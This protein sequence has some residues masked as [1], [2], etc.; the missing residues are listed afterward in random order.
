MSV[1]RGDSCGS[2]AESNE[3]RP[4]LC[5]A[6]G[7]A[8][9]SCCCVYQRSAAKPRRKASMELAASGEPVGA[10]S[11]SNAVAS[12]RRAAE[13]AS[14]GPSRYRKRPQ[15]L[16]RLELGQLRSQCLA[17]GHQFAVKRPAA[18]QRLLTAWALETLR[19]LRTP[20]C[21]AFDE[22]LV[23]ACRCCD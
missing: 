17:R 23:T 16:E 14:S 21:Y 15:L 20:A 12:I 19:N 3:L 18:L 5:L 2:R 22:C 9:A 6:P 8:T 1:W 4:I 13:G 11:S 7:T 10:R